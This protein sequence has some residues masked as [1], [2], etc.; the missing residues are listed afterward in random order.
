[1]GIYY[2]YANAT[3]RE[4]FPI[5]ALGGGLKHNALGFTLASRAFHLLLPGEPGHGPGPPDR[6]YGRWAGDSIF[7]I[8]DDLVPDWNQ[9]VSEYTNIEADAILLVFKTDGFDGIGEAAEKEDTLYM[10][11]CHLAVTGQAPQLEAE[12]KRRFGTGYLQR[13]TSLCRV[14]GSFAPKD[15]KIAGTP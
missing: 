2:Y 1:M 6:L 13:Y 15:L 4:C 5:D 11:L 14:R 8:G 12:L 9:F 10:Q 7:I 3:K